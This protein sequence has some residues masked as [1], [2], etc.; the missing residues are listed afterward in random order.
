MANKAL[1][2]KEEQRTDLAKPERI[3]GGISFTPRCD[4]VETED[5]LVL[6]ADLPG[7]RP[8]DVDVHLEN[9]ELELSAKC[10]PRQQPENYVS[11][12]YGIGDFYR[13]FTLHES[14]NAEKIAAEMKQGVLTVHLPKSEAVKPKRIAVKSA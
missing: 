9:G 12:E 11:C 10:A 13:S 5:E 6:Y 14:I 7:V 4:I 1:M 3:R 8:E 2:Q